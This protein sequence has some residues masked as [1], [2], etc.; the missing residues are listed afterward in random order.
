MLQQTHIHKEKTGMGNG[1]G[2]EVICSP[3]IRTE[4]M[5]MLCNETSYQKIF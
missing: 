1:V 2:A 4:S 5:K 3:W